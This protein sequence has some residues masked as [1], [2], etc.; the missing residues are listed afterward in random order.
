M[1]IYHIS[2]PENWEKFKGKPSYQAESLATE[3][4]IHCSYEQQ[5]PAVLKRYYSGA[6]RVVILKLDTAKLLSKL[7][8]EPSTN[9]EIYPHIYGRINQNAIVDV[10]ERYLS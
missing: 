2:L 3:G 6:E 4:F 7:V 9:N 1:F 8:E 10:E 5:L